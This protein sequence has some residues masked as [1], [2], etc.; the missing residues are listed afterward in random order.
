[1]SAQRFVYETIDLQA[2]R[3]KVIV[4]GRLPGVLRDA[5]AMKNVTLVT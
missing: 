2:R 1:M 4:I 5:S 3:G